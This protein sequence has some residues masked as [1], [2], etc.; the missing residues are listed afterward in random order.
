MFECLFM[1]MRPPPPFLQ[2]TYRSC[3]QHRDNE[4]TDVH[5]HERERQACTRAR[6][7]TQETHESE[8]KLNK[9]ET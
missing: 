7:N 5:A 6:A 2:Y 8:N 9:T 1:G 4:K 3:W